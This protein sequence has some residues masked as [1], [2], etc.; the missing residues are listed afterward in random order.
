MK[1]IFLAVDYGYE[2]T[3]ILGAY[4]TEEEA[5]KHADHRMK[6]IQKD[7]DEMAKT[8]IDELESNTEEEREYWKNKEPHDSTCVDIIKIKDSFKE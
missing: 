7:W 5:Q 8:M 1:T 4:S 3:N 6:E 2:H